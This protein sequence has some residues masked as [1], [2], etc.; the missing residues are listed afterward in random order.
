VRAKIF[1]LIFTLGIFLRVFLLDDESLW[2]DEGTSLRIAKMKTLEIVKLESDA[3]PPL[4]YLILHLWIKIFGDSEFSVRFPS[5]IF[6]SATIFIVFKLLSS[7]DGEIALLSSLLTSISTFLVF[8]S[9][10]ARAYSLFLM[11]SALSY[12]FLL[13]ALRKGETKFFILYTLSV[14]LMLYT[15][16]YSF[17]VV[18]SHIVF[19]SLCYINRIKKFSL[20]FSLSLLFYIPR[21]IVVF[22][23]ARNITSQGFWLP[24]PSFIDIA[25]TLIQF[26]GATYPMP[27]DETG[28]VILKS[29]IVEYFPSA[30]LL[31]IFGVLIL[32]LHLNFKRIDPEK[33]NFILMLWLWFLSPIILP[34]ILSQ[35]LTPFYFTRYAIPSSVAFYVL[36]SMGFEF[37]NKKFKN[38]VLLL[39]IF[40]SAVNLAWYY[41]KTNKE[42][43]RE[44]VKFVEERAQGNDLVVAS[45]YVFYYYFKRTDVKTFSFQ[46]V[47]GEEMEKQLR[48]FLFIVKDY[49]RVWFVL[50]HPWEIER[51][52]FENLKRSMNIT[53]RKKFLGIDVFLFEGGAN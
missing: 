2:L 25:K 10:E 14:V 53:L 45:K 32:V 3:N 26:S 49:K 5:L 18:F 48:D 4:Y 9:Q 17:F 31:F 52:A 16:I 19:V 39:I 28:N 37:I 23:Q 36:V 29:F 22:N 30:V 42:Q 35:F 21:A 11:I 51:N 43:W 50:S 13:E 40:L 24:K 8:Y 15:H 27:R 12:L 46:D 6:G 34:F 38:V 44:A 7:F 20:F 33:R 47:S 1:I 41:A